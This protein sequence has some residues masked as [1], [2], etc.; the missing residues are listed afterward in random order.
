[1]ANC[2]DYS[3]PE[4]GSTS[5]AERMTRSRARRNREERAAR[6]EEDCSS[7]TAREREPTLAR[8]TPWRGGPLEPDGAREREPT[9]ARPTPWRGG[10]LEPGRLSNRPPHPNGV[11]YRYSTRRIQL[12]STLDMSTSVPIAMLGYYR[13]RTNHSVA[14]RGRLPSHLSAL[15][16]KEGQRCFKCSH[17]GMT[18][19]V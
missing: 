12:P 15:Y 13:R 19:C 9:L 10:L 14:V 16:L 1:M 11:V 7:Q 4:V 2:V 3:V 5:G 6:C 17:S 18:L 8:P